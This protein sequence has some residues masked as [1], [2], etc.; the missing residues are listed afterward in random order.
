M[1]DEVV[2]YRGKKYTVVTEKFVDMGRRKHTRMIIKDVKVENGKCIV[3]VEIRR[4]SNSWKKGYGF[5]AELLKNWDMK[6]FTDRV[7]T[8]ALKLEEDKRFEERVLMRLE[9]LVDQTITLD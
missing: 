8:D 1:S 9:H 7:L 6:A 3:A 2:E 5:D 4:G